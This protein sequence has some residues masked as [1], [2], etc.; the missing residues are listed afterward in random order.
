MNFCMKRLRTLKSFKKLK[1]KIKNQ[2]P[3]VVAMSFSR[4][5]QWYRSHVDPIWQDG[6]FKMCLGSYKCTAFATL[7]LM[8][9]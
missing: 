2:K 7:Y 6:T 3:T 4:P 1:I 9:S 8:P 5:I